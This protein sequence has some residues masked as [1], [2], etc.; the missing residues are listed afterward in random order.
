MSPLFIQ[1]IKLSLALQLTIFAILLGVSSLVHRPSH[2]LSPIHSVIYFIPLYLLGIIYSIKEDEII[3]V[4]KDKC[5][6]LGAA[7]VGISMIQVIHNN[8]YG[9]YQ[10][11]AILSYAGF[12]LMI[13]QKTLMIFFIL[14][15]LKKI[16]DKEIWILKY[17]ASIS[18]ALFFLHPWVLKTLSWWD[19]TQYLSF[20]PGAIIFPIQTIFVIIVSITIATFCKKILSHRSLYI[21]GY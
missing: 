13:I 16:D 20:I 5:L 6:A 12:D 11:S 14:S 8:S 18:F 4:I 21:I 9:N 10:K 2:N 7:T 3:K 1:Y 19:I 15:I 17:L